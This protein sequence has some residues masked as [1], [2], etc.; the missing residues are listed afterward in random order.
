MIN[1]LTDFR[2]NFWITELSEVDLFLTDKH[3]SYKCGFYRLNIELALQSLFGLYV[4]SCISLAETPPPPPPRIWAHI[5]GR[6]WSA[7]ID[8][9]SLYPLVVSKLGC[10]GGGN[11]H[12]ILRNFERIKS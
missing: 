9:I 11:F 6:Y 10:I 8:D 7:E 2:K 3:N 4:H 1:T 5:R 12:H